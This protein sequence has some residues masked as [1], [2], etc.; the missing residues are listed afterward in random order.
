MPGMTGLDLVAELRANGMLVNA[1]LITAAPSDDI[2]RRAGELGVERVLTKPPAE[3]DLV[4]FVLAH[5]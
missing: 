4:N 2:Y 1:L 3:E 5:R